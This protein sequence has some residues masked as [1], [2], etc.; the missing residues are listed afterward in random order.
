MPGHRSATSV[1]PPAV[2]SL[3]QSSDPCTPSSAENSTKPPRRTTS[4][5]APLSLPGQMSFTTNVPALV[6]SLRQSSLPRRGLSAVNTTT[7]PSSVSWYG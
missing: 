6:P 4:N 7:P 3:R 1:V 2:P 5:G